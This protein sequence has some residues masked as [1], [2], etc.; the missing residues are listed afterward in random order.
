MLKILHDSATYNVVYL[1]PDLQAYRTDRFQ[2]WT[3]QPAEIGPVLFSNTSPSYAL[4]EPVSAEDPEAAAGEGG[5]DEGFG[6]VEILAILAGLLLLGGAIAWIVMRRR[7][8]DER[9]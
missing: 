4:L 1:S 9:E 2:G 5:E 6:A 8:A 7:T 3:R